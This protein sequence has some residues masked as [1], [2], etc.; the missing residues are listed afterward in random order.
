VNILQLLQAGLAVREQFRDVHGSPVPLGQG[1][2]RAWKSLPGQQAAAAS[3]VEQPQLAGT[4][5]TT[6]EFQH[7]LGVGA[8]QPFLLGH[9]VP[10][11][12]VK[13]AIASMPDRAKVCNLASMGRSLREEDE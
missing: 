12:A 10:P 4:C 7:L 6:Q 11:S 1:S 9:G 8:A 13:W 3:H 5:L 2:F